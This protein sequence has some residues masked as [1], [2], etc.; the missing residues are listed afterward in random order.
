M[1]EEQHKYVNFIIDDYIKELNA[2]N[3]IKICEQMPGNMFHS[4][5]IIRFDGANNFVEVQDFDDPNGQFIPIV[6]SIKD[7]QSVGTKLIGRT[8][9]GYAGIFR[10]IS[11][12]TLKQ[13]IGPLIHNCKLDVIEKLEQ[14][15]GEVPIKTGPKYIGECFLSFRKNKQGNYFTDLDNYAAFQLTPYTN[16]GINPP[17]VIDIRTYDMDIA[18][19]YWNISFKK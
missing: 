17:E 15:Y 14:K 16:C 8:L 13:S 7:A 9:I 19:K 3:I 2:P 6:G 10:G 4:P 11:N 5:V 18:K 1:N 12:K